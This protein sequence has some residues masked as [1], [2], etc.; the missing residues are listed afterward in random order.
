[1]KELDADEFRRLGHMAVEMAAEHMFGMRERPVH[2]AMISAERQVIQDASLPDG[3][4]RPSHILELIRTRILPHPL[5]NGHPR[6]FGWAST[7]PSSMGVLAELL[8]AAMNPL[9]AND[10]T[11]DHAAKYVER[12]ALRWLMELIGFPVEDSAGM[13]VSDGSLAS[14]LCLDAAKRAML[15]RIV[16][17]AAEVDV[18]RIADA[19][20]VVYV[21]ELAPSYLPAVAHLLGVSPE[22]VRIIPSVEQRMD[23]QALHDAIAKDQADGFSPFCVCAS[24]GALSTGL[25]DRLQQLSQIC[26]EQ[27]VWFHVDGSIGG[28]AALDPGLTELDALAWADSVVLE[29]QRWLGVPVE[30]AVAFVRDAAWL[31]HADAYALLRQGQGFRALKLW[32]TLLHLGR[33]GIRARIELHRALARALAERIDREPLLELM[34]QPE[35]AIVC[36]RYI[37]IAEPRDERLDVFNRAL[38]GQLQAEGEV[39]VS[40]VS[41]RGCYGLHASIMHHATR[42][43]D[44]S[45]LVQIVLNAA[46][47]LQE[48]SLRLP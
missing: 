8:A 48:S 46:A 20:L 10:Q 25:I 34:V 32:A 12:C 4:M 16:G 45:L 19:K 21:S 7:A 27:S 26:A 28:L 36:F 5:G 37:G 1:M 42:G 24:A 35:L 43:S 6:Y 14:L 33:D 38:V 30:C 9:G 2:S 31:D 18:Q 39:Y 11:S 17:A 40:G 41:V 3:G 15:A 23:P 22:L 44:L 47:R 29:P 13:L